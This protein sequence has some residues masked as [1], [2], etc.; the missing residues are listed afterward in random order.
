MATGTARLTIDLPKKDHKKIKMAA[1]SLDLSMKDL[2]VLSVAA[3][4]SQKPNRVTEKALKQV[5]TGKGI[6]KFDSLSAML[7]DLKS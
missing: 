6:K 2:V 1:T 5:K 4:L 7:E 3:F